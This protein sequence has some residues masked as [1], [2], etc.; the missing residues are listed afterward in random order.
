M[1]SRGRG[2]KDRMRWD[3]TSGERDRRHGRRRAIIKALQ[4]LVTDIPLNVYV[5]TSFRKSLAR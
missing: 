5:D 4:L 3:N 1:F 2:R